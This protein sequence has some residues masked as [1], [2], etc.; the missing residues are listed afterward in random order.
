MSRH[1]RDYFDANKHGGRPIKATP[2]EVETCLWV[3]A[4][5]G[6][7]ATKAMRELREFHGWHHIS[8]ENL[9]QWSQR[10]FKARYEEICSEKATELEEIV[11]AR[12][13][14][15]VLAMAD[16]EESALRRVAAGIADSN[17]VEASIILRNLSQSK[18]VNVDKAGQLRGREAFKPGG[19]SI[20]ILLERVERL[21][22][23]VIEGRAEEV[24][25]RSIAPGSPGGASS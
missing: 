25:A 2:E 11:A 4:K 16:V 14:Q 12:A 23:G 6:G 5:H 22:L 1:V 10:R 15:Q 13:M 7:S 21:G 20:N 19:V 24:P 18:N 3:V 8:R 9:V 17:G